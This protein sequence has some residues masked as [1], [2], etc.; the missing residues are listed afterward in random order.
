MRRPLIRS[1]RLRLGAP[2]LG[3]LLSVMLAAGAV[4]AAESD[5]TVNFETWSNRLAASEPGRL[6][7]LVAGLAGRRLVLFVPRPEDSGA[8][9]FAQARQATLLGALERRGVVPEVVVLRVAG[10]SAGVFALKAMS[11]EPLRTPL[12]IGP[13][14]VPAVPAAD[15]PAAAGAV[16]AGL[17]PSEPIAIVPLGP[18][19]A[20]PVPATALSGPTPSGPVQPGPPQAAPASAEVA[21]PAVPAVQETPT[22]A[23]MAAE[24]WQANAGRSL[25]AVL[26]EWALMAG[27]T[28]VWRS[29]RD[30]PLEASAQFSGAFTKAASELLDG[31][32][33]A[34][35]APLGHFFKGNQVLLVDSGE[36]R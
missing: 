27:W 17:A 24:H 19:I 34:A 31:F 33:G 30:Y 16:A 14:A 25:R 21:P 28:I 8:R 2:R 18:S 15:M 3:M 6:D 4:Q 1:I 22:T 5:L 10:A 26:E 32:A 11:P 20:A 7:D 12:E 13:S 29:D 36:G 23:A 35:P 9:H